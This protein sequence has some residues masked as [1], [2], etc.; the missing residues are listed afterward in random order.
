MKWKNSH[1]ASRMFLPEVVVTEHMIIEA[2]ETGNLETLQEWA[3]YGVVRVTTAAPLFAAADGGFSDVVLI[4]VEDF[5]ADINKSDVNG[6]TALIH[7]A[8]RGHVAVVECL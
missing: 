4:L 3:E 5:G 8:L 1:G 2:A 7:T 6:D